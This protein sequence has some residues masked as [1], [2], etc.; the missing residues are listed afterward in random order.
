MIN[1]SGE[2]KKIKFWD[3]IA[4][5]YDREE[6]R[7]NNVNQL[8]I[9]KTRTLLNPDQVIL[10]LGCGTGTFSIAL[11][12]YVSHIDGIDFSS[13]MIEIAN[14][15]NEVKNIHKVNFFQSTIFDQH[16]RPESYDA[17]LCF[18]LFHLLDDHTEVINRIKSLL[19]PNGL[20]ISVT[21]CM[22]E[23]IIK[24]WGL[25]L[26]SLTGLVPKI[27]LLRRQNLI[28]LHSGNNLQLLNNESLTSAAN[29]Y[30]LVSK[31]IY[32]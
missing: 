6:E 12:D 19:K 32:Q 9:E 1:I 21:P 29:Q 10:D 31:K 28:K 2:K 16:L 7:D 27:K 18:Y 30:F 11:A 15:K 23:A 24:G 17:I 5:S 14:K 25:S 8:I 3:R 26:L 22:G 4:N 20:L 13:K